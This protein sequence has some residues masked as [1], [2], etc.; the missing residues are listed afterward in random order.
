MSAFADSILLGF[1]AFFL[2]LILG[3]IQ[4]LLYV[5]SVRLVLEFFVAN[6][7]TAQNTSQLVEQGEK[8]TTK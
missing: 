1:L 2:T 6:I 4:Y 5:I 7:R 3:G 8:K